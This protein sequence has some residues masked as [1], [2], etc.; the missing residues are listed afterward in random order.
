MK[1]M[2]FHKML[3]SIIFQLIIVEYL[4]RNILNIHVYLIKKHNIKWLLGFINPYFVTTLNFG[5]S[6]SQSVKCTTL[7]N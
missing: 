2:K 3:L 7:L 6:F 4:K 1:T 5:R